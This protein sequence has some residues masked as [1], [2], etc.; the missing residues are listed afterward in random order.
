MIWT[1]TK[2]E[3]LI[4]LEKLNSKH[5]T[6]KFEHNISNRS[7]SFLDTLIYK[8]KN[9]T[10]QATLYWKPTDQQ[11]YLLAH[12]DHIKSLKRSIPYNQ[13][14]RIKTICS[15]LTKYKKHCAILKEKFIERG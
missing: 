15:T 2:R 10:Q 12:L 6:I 1:E 9:S 8:D 13:A 7:I 4:F 14:L 5:K 11:S 3:L